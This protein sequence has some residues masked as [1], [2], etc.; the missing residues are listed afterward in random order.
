M[1]VAKYLVTSII[2]FEISL[3]TLPEKLKKNEI[4]KIIVDA[5]NNTMLSPMRRQTYDLSLIFDGDAY[6]YD[7]VDVLQ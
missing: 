4:E 1:I 7:D 5:I 2:I 3:S 6:Q